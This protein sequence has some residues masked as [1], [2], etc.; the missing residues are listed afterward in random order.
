[1]LGDH[2]RRYGRAFCLLMN[3]FDPRVPCKHGCKWQA[4]HGYI[5]DTICPKHS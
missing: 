4:P 2:H 1:M 3:I 5:S